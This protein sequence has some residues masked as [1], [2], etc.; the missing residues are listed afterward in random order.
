MNSEFRRILGTHPA[1]RSILHPF[2]CSTLPHFCSLLSLT[3][4]Y[5]LNQES[6]LSESPAIRLKYSPMFPPPS[7]EPLPPPLAHAEPVSWIT[8][9]GLPVYVMCR[10]AMRGVTYLLRQEGVDGSQKPDV[11]HKGTAGF[12][13]Y[14]PGNYSCSYLTHAA[15]E[16]SEPSAIVTIKMRGEC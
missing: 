8:P 7:T 11:E 9:G 3:P 16:P 10:V 15:G 4:F 2:S 1:Q 13:I 6:I 12:L 14:K 5:F